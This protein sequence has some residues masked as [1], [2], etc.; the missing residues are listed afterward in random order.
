M[1]MIVVDI[2]SNFTENETGKDICPLITM[3]TEFT[4]F[5]DITAND[6]IH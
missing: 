5:T 4:E 1:A 3:E 2:H 6:R